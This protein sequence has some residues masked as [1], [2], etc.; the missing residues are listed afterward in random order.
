M[1]SMSALVTSLTRCCRS[2]CGSVGRNVSGPI[3]GGDLAGSLPVRE[4]GSKHGGRQAEPGILP[5]LPVRERGSKRAQD[6]RAPTRPRSLPVRERGSKH[7]QDRPA[8]DQPPVAPCAGAWVETA[9]SP[10][11][12]RRGRVASCAGAWVETA[13]RPGRRERRLSLPVRERGSKRPGAAQGHGTGPSLPVRE[14]G[15][16]LQ[17]IGFAVQIRE[18]LL[19]GSVGRNWLDASTFNRAC[20][21]GRRHASSPDH[22][23]RRRDPAALASNPSWGRNPAVNDRR[24]WAPGPDPGFPAA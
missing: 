10:M 8:E 20:G 21:R 18:S 2:L 12:S 17:G 22:S 23:H 7:L 15:S 19:C 6:H 5:S 13:A 24:D 16:K 4:R 3:P 11:C 14:R 9:P 1:L